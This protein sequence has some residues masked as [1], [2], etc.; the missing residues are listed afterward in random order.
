MIITAGG[1]KSGRGAEKIVT[2]A[3]RALFVGGARLGCCA[4]A[5]SPQ[6]L[7][8]LLLCHFFWIAKGACRDFFHPWVRQTK[9]NPNCC[10]CEGIIVHCGNAPHI[11]SVSVGV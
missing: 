3:A 1:R 6:T 11:F 9:K 5:A 7:K 2:L 4:S 8:P 10:I